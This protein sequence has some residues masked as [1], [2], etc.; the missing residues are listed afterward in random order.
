MTPQEKQLLES[1]LAD[2]TAARAA[3]KDAEA[4]ALIREAVSRQPDA[5]YLLV[6]R[7]IQLDQALALTQSEVQK[8][9]GELAQAKGSG[10]I[11]APGGGFLNDP[12]AWGS[13][14]K[15]ASPPH[16]SAGQAGGNQ[17]Q[18]PQQAG[19]GW[20]G[21]GMLGTVASTAAGVVAGSFLFQ[22]IQSLLNRNDESAAAEPPG[23][24]AA[25][26]PA[27]VDPVALED[28]AVDDSSDTFAAGDDGGGDFA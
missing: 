8:L 13:Q 4:E 14:R 12:Y 19:R 27:G 2:M 18:P 25:A 17:A 26:E 21:S 28:T 6:Q 20:G 9:K 15:A 3:Q 10:K 23:A 1:F 7:A 24:Q 5:A 16:N 22:G 11:A